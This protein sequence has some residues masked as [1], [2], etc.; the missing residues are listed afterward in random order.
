MAFYGFRGSGGFV[1]E[2]RGRRLFVKNVRQ[3]MVLLPVFR[4]RLLDYIGLILIRERLGSP[5]PFP[6][7]EGLV[8]ACT[9]PANELR[10]KGPFICF[11]TAERGAR[12]SPSPGS[13]KPVGPAFVWPHV[14]SLSPYPAP[15]SPLPPP[16]HLWPTDRIASRTDTTTRQSD[17]V[18]FQTTGFSRRTMGPVNG[19]WARE[20]LW[21]PVPFHRGG[22]D[23]KGRVIQ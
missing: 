2:V 18:F 5:P 20:P 23:G 21:F 3:A 1:S 6:H 10:R 7:A 9:A 15:L 14:F 11:T 4:G 19:Q 8:L 12:G 16:A 13:K 22:G 17:R